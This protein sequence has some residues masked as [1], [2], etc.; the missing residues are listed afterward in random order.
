MLLPD[1]WQ[2][3]ANIG[4]L[5]EKI[6]NIFEY[7]YSSQNLAYPWKLKVSNLYAYATAKIFSKISKLRVSNLYAYSYCQNI[8]KNFKIE[9]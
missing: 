7:M 2:I 8:C 3:L 1:H 4:K 5:D 6:S 9:S